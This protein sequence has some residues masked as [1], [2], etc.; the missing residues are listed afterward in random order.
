MNGFFLES[1]NMTMDE[2]EDLIK[3][4]DLWYENIKDDNISINTKWFK[5]PNENKFE[6]K[7]FTCAHFY[8]DKIE[9]LDIEDV[10][11]F[12]NFLILNL[13]FVAEYE[14]GL[15]KNISHEYIKKRLLEY[16]D[17]LEKCMT[18]D[19]QLPTYT[20]CC[21]FKSPLNEFDLNESKN[22]NILDIYKFKL[23]LV[24]WSHFVQ[25]C[26]DQVYKVIKSEA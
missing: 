10:N 12:N 21:I 11:Y 5:Y 18:S 13:A 15:D 19:N 3:K 6:I 23:H 1:I 22:L 4:S 7:L 2:I 24:H 17:D 9:G 25:K 20:Y 26:V 8:N 14:Y 16:K